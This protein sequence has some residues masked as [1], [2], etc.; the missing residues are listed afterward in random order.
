M[1]F[2]SPWLLLGIAGA[3]VPLG[4]HLY[5]RR[6]A[7]IVDLDAVMRLVLS[8]G[9][10]RV[11]LRMVHAL[12]LTAR[13]L[14]VIALAALFARPF[15]K[16]T[17]ESGVAIEHPVA[18]AIVLDN[19]LSMRLQA[20]GESSFSRGRARALALLRDLP[21]ESEVFVVLVGNPIESFP[22]RA[23]WDPSTA[24]RFVGRIPVGFGAGD[25]SESVRRA[26]ERVRSSSRR[27]RRIAIVSDF[28]D[29][30]L[31][32]FPTASELAGI[33]ILPLD[34]GPAKAVTNRALVEASSFPAP[35]QSPAHVRVRVVVANESDTPFD[36]V[37]TVRIGQV[38]TARKVACEAR[39]RC[40]QEFLLRVDEGET[41]GL[42]RLPPDGL[43]NDDERWFT[44]APRNQNAALLVDGSPSRRPDHAESFFL[45]RALGLRSGD[46]H[47]FTVTTVRP[48]E[49]S[50][51]HLSSVGTV[52]LLNIARLDPEQVKAVHDFVASGGGLLVTLGD[53]T[54]LTSW[55][56]GFGDLLPAPLRDLVGSPS[57][58]DR[59]APSIARVLEDH[60]IVRGLTG[61]QGSIFS[62]RV[63]RWGVLQDGWSP[64]ASALCWLG[65]G[66]PLLVE[67]HLGRGVVLTLLTSADRDWTD[68]P[69]RPAF[70]AFARQAFNHLR[71]AGGGQSRTGFRVGEPLPVELPDGHER[72]E[73]VAPGNATL[74]FTS[75]TSFRNTSVPGVYTIRTF[76]PGRP[77]PART[78]PI[79]VNTDPSESRLE[80]ATW[81]EGVLPLPAVATAEGTPVRR[82]ELWPYLLVLALLL[83]LAESYLRGKA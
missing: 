61:A 62:S 76:L 33:T 3:L 9:R 72:G 56:A 43:P 47:G 57:D 32:R 74:R 45:A 75:T 53:N 2:E 83:L 55:S 71:G 68:L 7:P 16:R 58:D 81:D 30:G 70:P 10:T 59:P 69:L 5:V 50:P 23:S 82:Q 35:D 21:D 48:D 36:D 11:R 24:A 13:V 41:F 73:V 64:G 63:R 28:F 66:A 49:L 1:D 40:A 46:D 65:N 29:H 31:A 34:T 25:V 26:A 60:P 38:S 39:S 80:H 27:D 19:S 79:V 54:D 6:R 78:Y 44:L 14:I 77:D 17:A 51:L 15:L 18:L 4:I 42:A 20:D 37:V 8:G 67:H 22:A 52:A 12:L